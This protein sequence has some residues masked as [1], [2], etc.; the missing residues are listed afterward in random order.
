MLSICA[1]IGVKIPFLGYKELA[2][3]S[4]NLNKGVSVGIDAFAVK[5]TVTF[6][7]RNGKELW[8]KLELSSPFF[9]TISQEF[10]IFV[11]CKSKFRYTR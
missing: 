6:F 3:I 9:S 7:L 10:K 2:A 5:G 11:I 8:I 1:S 4:G